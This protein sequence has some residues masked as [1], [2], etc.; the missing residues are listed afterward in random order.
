SNLDFKALVLQYMPNGNLEMLLHSGF[1]RLL[2][3]PRRVKIMLDVSMAIE[4]LHHEHCQVVV[5]CDLKPSNVLFDDDLV[6]HVA[7]FG[8]ANLLLGDDNSI[9]TTSLHGILGYMAPEYGSLGKASCKSDVFSYGI[10]L[11]EVFT[12]KRPTDP[13][14]TGDMSI[15]QWVHRAFPTELSSVVDGQL[16]QD[17][18]SVSDLNDFLQQIFEVGLL[19][20][21]DSPNK[22][23]SM[24][25]VVM[26]M[27]KI[28]E[29]YT[30]AS[31]ETAHI[32]IHH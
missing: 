24:R 22:R 8:V 27:K 26:A 25:A 13:M 11:L 16:I 6:A 17:A 9:I 30:K 28:K 1:R 4:Y 21:S 14:F 3:L 7:D 18:S 12:G 23:M 5:H 31:S 10:M 19:C 15:R 32:A 2:D 29:G 20:T